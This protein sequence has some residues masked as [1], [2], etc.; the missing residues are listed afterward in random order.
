M[1]ER[2]TEKARRVIFFARYEASLFGANAID[3]EHIL[4]GIFRED[5]QLAQRFFRSPASTVESIR[6]QIE[7]RTALRDRIPQSIDLPLSQSAR[8]V[9][10]FAADE[11]D[12]FQNRHIGTEHLLLGILREE[13]SPAA[14]MLYERG[15]S[16]EKVL[17]YIKEKNKPYEET[18]ETGQEEPVAGKPGG[19]PGTIG[20]ARGYSSFEEFAAAIAD[21]SGV[22]ELQDRFNQL[23][24]L[25]VQK[26]VIGEAEKDELKRDKN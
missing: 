10:S 4:L 17:A 11:S 12:R 19:I 5:K 24:D 2:Y 16:V 25:L 26:G 23:L 22:A 21:Q 18:P 7:G 15:L 13:K 14:E 6:K 20:V 3:A 1:F 8:R 9:L